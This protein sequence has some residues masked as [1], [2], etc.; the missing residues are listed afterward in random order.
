M[1]PQ[2]PAELI[3][4]II[5]SLIDS[6]PP[7]AYLPSDLTTRTLVSL[8]RVSRVTSG[9]ARYLLLKHCLCI[10]TEERFWKFISPEGPSLSDPT[11][12]AVATS[13]FLS[14]IPH[15]LGKSIEVCKSLDTLLS[16]LSGTLTRLVIDI[17]L[18]S[19]YPDADKSQVR[20]KL[21]AAF[22]RLTALEEFC[23]VQDELYLDTGEADSSSESESESDTDTDS[24]TEAE[25]EVDPEPEP[26]ADTDTNPDPESE[27][28]SD[29]D[30]ESE[31]EPEPEVWSLWPRLKRLALYNV[32]L[33]NPRF[34]TSLQKCT[35]LTHLVLCRV[36][37]LYDIIPE[38]SMSWYKSL[39]NLKR[40][41]M[42][43]IDMVPTARDHVEWFGG[44]IL[45]SLAP[46]SSRYAEKGYDGPLL[47]YINVPRAWV[48]SPGLTDIRGCQMWVCN[49][50]MD[51]TLWEAGA[52]YFPS[53]E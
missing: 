3:L 51:G 17:P 5:N 21:R 8:T 18:R 29:S 42:V 16:G 34:L 53:D 13:L 44:Q 52:P 12:A 35:N 37:G 46:A 32:D 36:D 40:V 10:N 45:E 25:A 7:I 30:T 41:T 23:S 33:S 11:N 19:L 24:D 43:N 22:S 31:S 6:S 39:P 49:H 27:S 9:T 38:E 15:S 20:P 2:L 50:A 14:P 28:E 47:A 1:P 48:N 4:Q 26:A